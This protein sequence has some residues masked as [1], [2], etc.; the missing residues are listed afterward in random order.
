MV[1]TVWDQDS[2]MMDL[3][4]TLEHTFDRELRDAMGPEVPLMVTNFST[5]FAQSVERSLPSA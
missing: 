1:Q 2:A 3:I 5:L 4:L